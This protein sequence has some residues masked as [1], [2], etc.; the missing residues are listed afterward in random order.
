MKTAIKQETVTMCIKHTD[1]E[2]KEL[3]EL[4]YIISLSINDY[5]R[6]NGI[7]VRKHSRH[8]PTI[9]AVRQGSIEMDLVLTVIENIAVGVAVELIAGY[10]KDRICMLWEKYKSGKA[11]TQIFNYEITT[12][13]KIQIEN[14]KIIIIVKQ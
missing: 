2:V 10:I 11:K 12:R 9:Q 4:L 14:G 7:T 13:V 3:S 1:L 6:E 5:Y 8:A